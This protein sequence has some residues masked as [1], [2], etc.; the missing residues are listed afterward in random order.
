MIR[1]RDTHYFSKGIH[2]IYI[3]T[4]AK[5]YSCSRVY[6]FFDLPHPLPLICPLD[7]LDCLL[8]RGVLFLWLFGAMAWAPTTGAMVAETWAATCRP[9]LLE[10]KRGRRRMKTFMSLPSEPGEDKRDIAVVHAVSART[11]TQLKFEPKT[12]Q[13]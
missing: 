4:H 11:Q 13:K 6:S 2:N 8:L 10:R 12:D 7:R 9:W 1:L 5:N 3:I